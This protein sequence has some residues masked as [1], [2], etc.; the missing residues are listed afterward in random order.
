MLEKSFVSISA[1]S[2][3]EQLRKISEICGKEEIQFPVAIGYQ[4][5]NKSINQGTQN[6]RQPKFIDL[7]KL[8]EETLAYGMIPAIHY[9]TK[10]NTT[11]LNDLERI[12]EIGVNPKSALLQFNTLPLSPEIL[13]SVKKM[14]FKVLF[15]VAVSD[16][17]SP[18]G[19]YSVWKGEEVQDA[20]NGEVDTLL[21]QVLERQGLINYAMFDPSHGTNLDLNID[22]NS[23]AIRFGK[24]IIERTELNHLGLVYAGGINACNVTPITEYLC[25][26]FPNRVSIDVESGVRVNDKLNLGLVRNYLRGYKKAAR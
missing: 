7:G 12:V 8:S 10:D 15:K 3:R 18:E 20:A 14:G 17:Q 19:G 2:N 13:S 6:P 22:E 11:V 23:L 26:F 16:K 25:S 9:H 5:S 24:A 1:V 21:N 4:V